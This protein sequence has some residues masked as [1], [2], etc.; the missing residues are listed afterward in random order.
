M[1][2]DEYYVVFFLFFSKC[3]QSSAILLIPMISSEKS[4]KIYQTAISCYSKKDLKLIKT[5]IF[6]S[7]KRRNSV[8]VFMI[9]LTRPSE[10][11]VNPMPY[12]G[13]LCLCPFDLRRGFLRKAIRVFF[14]HYVEMVLDKKG[15]DDD[16]P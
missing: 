10:K 4:S 8:I 15:L 9:M 5:Q 13:Y 6:S 3:F 1:I 2:N 14:S 7:E 16:C 11:I 12:T